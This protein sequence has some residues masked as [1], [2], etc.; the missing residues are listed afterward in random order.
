MLHAFFDDDAAE[1]RASVL[2]R[3]ANPVLARV[4]LHGLTTERLGRSHPVDLDVRVGYTGSGTPNPLD[5]E[6]PQAVVSTPDVTLWFDG[7]T[8]KVLGVAHRDRSVTL[9]ATFGGPVVAVA[10]NEA[11]AFF[12]TGAPLVVW[13]VGVEVGG[14]K[15]VD[16]MPSD[17]RA[18]AVDDDR[19]YVASKADGVVRGVGIAAGVTNVDYA[20]GEGAPV[21]VARGQTHVYW[22]ATS[23]KAIRRAPLTGGAV[24]TVT[25]DVCTPASMA[26]A[27]DSFY[28]GC[29]DGR[30]QRIRYGAP[31]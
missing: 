28:V 6:A 20:T 27:G 1:D 18:L 24:E 8:Q 23:P 21:A 11:D 5:S 3:D 31:P 14:S 16:G 7:V 4:E 9:K 17:P 22:A 29:E 13:R 15:R 26:I 12:A 25:T 10:A 30:V 19:V 2:G